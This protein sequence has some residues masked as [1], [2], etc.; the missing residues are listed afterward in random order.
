LAARLARSNSIIL[1]VSRLIA[2]R[3]PPNLVCRPPDFVY[4]PPNYQ[5][6]FSQISIYFDRPA[7]NGYFDRP[8]LNGYFDRRRMPQTYYDDKYIYSVDMMFVYLNHYH[9]IVTKLKV[10]DLAAKIEQIGWEDPTGKIYYA[11]D[12]L[13]Y[14]KKY[15]ND[16]KRIVNANL[17]YPVILI[18]QVKSGVEV[19]TIVDG[20]H[21]MIK[22]NMAGKKTINANIFDKT[23]MKKFIIARK[24]EWRIPNNM[25]PYE[26]MD[27][28]LKRFGA[29]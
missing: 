5:N 15:K 6:I 8:A 27:L 4:Q 17:K 13:K 21:R 20:A 23:L 22:A 7:L 19:F 16:Y 25:K 10:A 9:H 2:V 3:R 26:F 11:A 18:S 14:P 24:G 1:A 29:S 28:Y 12:V